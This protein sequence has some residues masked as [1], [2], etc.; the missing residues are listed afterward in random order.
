[1]FLGAHDDD[2]FSILRFE[3]MLKTNKV[4]FFDSEEFEDIIHHYLEGGK[5][6]LAKRALKMGLQ[7]HP[8]SIDLRLFQ[9]EIYLFEDKLELAERLIDT[10][11][12]IDPNNEE[13][14]IQRANMLSKKSLHHKAIEALETALKFSLE[15][16]EIYAMLG[17]EYL[18][19]ENFEKAKDCFIACLLEDPE[20]HTS[21]YNVVYC[22]EFL[23]KVDEAV[24]FLKEFINQNPYSEIAWHQ[25]G[26]QLCV[27]K[28]YEEALEAYEYANLI[29]EHFMGAYIEKGKVLEKL[30]KY[31]QAIDNYKVTLT[32]EDPSSF[33]LLRIGKCY[34]KMHKMRLAI[35]F[36]RDAV[37]VDPLLDKG[38]LAITRFYY[39]QE[40]YQKALESIN[41]AISLDGENGQYW[42][43]AAQIHRKVL[44]FDQAVEAYAKSI[45]L[46]TFKLSTW[47]KMADLL[48]H[49]REFEHALDQMIIADTLFPNRAKIYYRIAGLFYEKNRLDKAEKYLVKAFALHPQKDTVLESLFMEFYISK[50]FSDWLSEYKSKHP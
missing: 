43:M 19:V 2:N 26:R 34:E 22:F 10:L 11:E 1:M 42:L 38:W 46:G 45:S 35:R 25:L 8:S 32:I 3:S 14:F 21:L 37:H 39:K 31:Q 23:E 20:D 50:F 17:M 7:Q 33:A 12:K 28:R 40:K 27:L 5:I 24:A 49:M 48:I 36:Y 18:F 30:K 13:I 29:D 47:L 15:P 4:L 41:K 6:T 16:A 44:D 9:V